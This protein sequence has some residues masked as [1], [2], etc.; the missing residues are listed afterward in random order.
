LNNRVILLT[1]RGP[2]SVRDR[3]HRGNART[4]VHD[5]L[6]WFTR[7]KRSGNETRPHSSHVVMLPLDGFVIGVTADRRWSEQAELFERR[8]ASVLHGPT[9]ST[10]YLGSDEQLRR[11]TEQVIARP[12]DYLVATTGI[13]VRAWF[14]TAQAW[15]LA[16]RLVAALRDAR[17]VARG[18]KASAAVQV[19]GLQVWASPA[20]ERLGEALALVAAGGPRGCTVALQ[21]YGRRDIDAVAALTTGGAEVIEVPVY[22]Y[23]APAD[24]APARRLVEAT[25][26]GEVDAVTFTSAPAVANF[27]Q[28]ARDVG[29][30]RDTLTACN[31]GPVTAACIGPICAQAAAAAGFTAA[32]APALGRLGLMVRVVTTVLESRRRTLRVGGAE[33]VVQGGAVAVDDRRVQLAPRERAVLDVL[34]ERRGT[35]VSKRVILESLGSDPERSHALEAAVGRLRRNLGTAGGAIRAVRGRGYILDGAVTNNQSC[36]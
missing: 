14:D 17:I 26:A 19:A 32:V 4:H 24:D 11:A 21:H 29:L 31:D 1:G 10:D 7:A 36:M 9:I 3:K 8:G 35:V 27:L 25:C 12:P 5:L 18:P 22:L 13:G 20:S 15:G 34:L 33:L 28:I 23:R 16:E 2:P 6:A 30:H